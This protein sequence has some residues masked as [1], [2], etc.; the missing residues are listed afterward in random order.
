MLLVI[1]SGPETKCY[2]IWMMFVFPIHG[3]QDSKGHPKILNWKRS[4]LSVSDTV[5]IDFV[6]IGR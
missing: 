6:N 2:R 3:G 4:V 1:M 5:V